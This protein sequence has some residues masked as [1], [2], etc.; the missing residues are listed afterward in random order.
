MVEIFIID[1]TITLRIHLKFK[2]SCTKKK[3][4]I[5]NNLKKCSLHIPNNMTVQHTQLTDT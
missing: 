1:K 4:E 2:N 5:N 3:K